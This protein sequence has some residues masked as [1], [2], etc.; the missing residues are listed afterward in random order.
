MEI[1]F[2]KGINFKFI[3]WHPKFDT[4]NYEFNTVSKWIVIHNCLVQLIHAK[5][6][7]EIGNRLGKFTGLEKN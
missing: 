3:D 4:N 1:V 6:L 5:I 7:I 2:Y